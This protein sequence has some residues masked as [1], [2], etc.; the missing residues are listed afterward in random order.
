MLN[1]D[2]SDLRGF[3]LYTTG[4]ENGS[5]DVNI[6]NLKGI[7]LF[8]YEGNFLRHTFLKKNLN[9]NF[10][11]V[12]ELSAL[13]AGGFYEEI[14]F[15]IYKS[16][17]FREYS[18]LTMY[19]SLNN[20]VYESKTL[21]DPNNP[22]SDFIASK[23]LLQKRAIAIGAL[24]KLDVNPSTNTLNELSMLYNSYRVA[25]CNHGY[26]QPIT[27]F[28]QEIPEPPFPGEGPGDGGGGDETDPYDPPICPKRSAERTAGSNYITS[29]DIAYEIR[30]GVLYNSFFGLK[31]IEYY[32]NTSFYDC[33]FDTSDAIKIASLMPKIYSLYEDFKSNK[34]SKVVF[35]DDF[36]NDIID[37]C[38]SLKSKNSNNSNLIMILNDVESDVLFLHNKS[39]QSLNE[40]LY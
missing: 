23:Q 28:I 1:V 39:L 33:K 7:S 21:S 18:N 38:E 40:I 14:N 4:T 5:D 31:Y 9:G 8:N 25:C 34:N 29:D 22:N 26:Y 32:Y 6:E 12:N 16:G 30:D 17:I 10:E 13:S 20:S 35:D 2:S 15:A 27:I 3:V 11:N 24:V 37:I 36:K 19:S